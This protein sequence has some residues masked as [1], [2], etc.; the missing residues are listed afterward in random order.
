[1]D[2]FSSPASKRVRH[3]ADELQAAARSRRKL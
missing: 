3:M 1:V 2:L